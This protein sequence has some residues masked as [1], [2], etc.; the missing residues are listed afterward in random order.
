MI[1]FIDANKHHVRLKVEITD[2]NHFPEFTVSGDVAG[3]SGQCQDKIKPRTDA[4]TMLLHFWDKN[5]LTDVSGIE[6]FGEAVSNVLDTIEA[7]EKIYAATQPKLE[8][9]DVVLAQMEEYGIDEDQLD[10]CKAYLETGISDDLSDFEESYSGQFA[11]DEE[12][13]KEQAESMGAIKDDISW[14]YSCI[15]WEWA[16]R[17]LMMDYSEDN[18]YYFRNI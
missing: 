11:N 16:A 15:D 14:P 3:H 4:Q 17:E 18:G 5:H 9:D 6:R 2:R 12:F 10:A 8:G 1:S 7:E 13:A